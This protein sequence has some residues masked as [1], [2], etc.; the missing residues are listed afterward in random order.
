MAFI[1]DQKE[2]LLKRH[3]KVIEGLKEINED[4]KREGG[5]PPYLNEIQYIFESFIFSYIEMLIENKASFNVRLLKY[6]RFSR[7]LNN[8]LGSI[9][10]D[11][12]LKRFDTDEILLLHEYINSELMPLIIGTFSYDDW[13]NWNM[14][15]ETEFKER[16]G[17]SIDSAV[18]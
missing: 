13:H 7:Q 15:L 8:E 10:T 18:F 12:H 1:T 17:Y 11:S 6:L 9:V 4:C 14:L 16:E 3:L 2:K 5:I